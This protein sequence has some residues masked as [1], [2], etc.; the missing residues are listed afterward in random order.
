MNNL[1]NIHKLFYK[2]FIE[3]NLDEI[4]RFNNFFYNPSGHSEIFNNLKNPEIE[5]QDLQNISN[6]ETIIND[7]RFDIE[8]SKD[9][10]HI[11]INNNNINNNRLNMYMN[12]LCLNIINRIIF[13]YIISQKEYINFK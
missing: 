2:S 13:E 8:E 3:Q 10:N 1:Y 11:G 4:K 12:I 7:M 6:V 9:L 5:N